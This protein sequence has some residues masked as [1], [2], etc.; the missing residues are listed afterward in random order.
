M[1]SIFDIRV[2]PVLPLR[3]FGQD[4]FLNAPG[5]V[6]MNGE[7]PWHECDTRTETGQ[8]GHR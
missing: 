3:A 4:M 7:L 2:R 6:T 8:W 5:P 1:T